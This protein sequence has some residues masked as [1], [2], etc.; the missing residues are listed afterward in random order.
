MKNNM[1]ITRRGALKA[2]AT[3]VA[4]A[5]AVGVLSDPAQ[6]QNLRRFEDQ[7]VVDAKRLILLKGGASAW[8]RRSAISCGGTC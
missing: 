6:A 1:R 4:G 8:T 2:G 7:P 5:A 3:V